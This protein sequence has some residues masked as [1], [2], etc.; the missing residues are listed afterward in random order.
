[1][2]SNTKEEATT[3]AP[4]K[5]WHN[6]SK[7]ALKQTML[8]MAV[9]LGYFCIGM[10]R[11]YSAP[12]MPSMQDLNPGLLPNQNIVSWASSIPPF[13]AFLG[14][15]VSAPLMH[16]IGRKYTVMITSPLWV[17]SWVLVATAEFWQQI[18]AGR[19]LM[20]FC[21]GLALP[22]VSVYVSECSDPAIRGV[23]GSFPG[24]AMSFGILVT[25]TMGTFLDWKLL[26]WV[27]SV[28]SSFLFFATCFMPKSPAWLKT[29]NRF[30][31]AKQ[32]CDWLHLSGF[33]LEQPTEVSKDKFISY[34]ALFSRACLMP[35][36]IG[37]GLL[38]IQQVSGIDAVVF[39]TVEIFRA[40]GSTLNSYYATIIVGA[41]QLLSNFSALFV[42]DKAG[43]KPLLVLSAIIMSGSMCSMGIAF[44]LKDN[45]ITSFGYLPL[46]SLIIFMI[47]FSIGFGTIPFLLM[48][49][50]FPVKQRSV[51]SSLAGSLNLLIMFLVIVSY[52]PVA[53]LITTAGTFWMY[54]IFCALGVFFV[55]FLV[56]E[57]K[58]EDLD[59]IA[60][61]FIRRLSRRFSRKASMNLAHATPIAYL[62][63]EEGGGGY[64]NKGM[65]GDDDGNKKDADVE[66][67]GGGE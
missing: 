30:D 38:I 9:S 31:E 11:G 47:G 6:I 28:I 48:G 22:A 43:R 56:P 39:F 67:D 26:A 64:T 42:V 24:L 58:G 7:A 59:S 25:Y 15:L 13:G 19:Y 27:C 5:K 45:G 54:S 65:S 40:A 4:N 52:H 57:T 23:I 18:V 14:S 60:N 1:M 61:K 41:V 2:V 49:E 35:L 32:S 53:D 21:A 16:K 50:L 20:G 29:K 10:V 51:L 34:K 37:L 66:G 12:A 36:G 44:H 17:I 8:S 62:E 3:T 46:I 55:I 33:S 63:G